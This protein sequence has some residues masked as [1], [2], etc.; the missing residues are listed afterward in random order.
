MDSAETQ[1]PTPKVM[2]PI[3]SCRSL[4]LPL[5]ATATTFGDPRHA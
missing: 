1:K 4:W 3:L 2:N 5:I